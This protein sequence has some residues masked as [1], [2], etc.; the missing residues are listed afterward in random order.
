LRYRNPTDRTYIWAYCNRACSFGKAETRT[1]SEVDK[2]NLSMALIDE[3]N[4][5]GKLLVEKWGEVET[6]LS[7]LVMDHVL[8]KP[9]SSIPA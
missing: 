6:K 5:D 9:G 2:D 8:A 4:A 1:F 3:L 7:D